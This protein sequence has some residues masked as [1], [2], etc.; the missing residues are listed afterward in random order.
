[1]GFT[2]WTD[3]KTIQEDLEVILGQKIKGQGYMVTKC[4]K[5]SIKVAG[6]RYITYAI[7]YRVQ[8]YRLV[9]SK[10]NARYSIS[11]SHKN[12]TQHTQS[13]ANRNARSKQWQP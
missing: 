6:V 12:F 3:L 9:T 11:Y 8:C 13:P 10:S 7:V 4:K 1:M 5:L 2:Q